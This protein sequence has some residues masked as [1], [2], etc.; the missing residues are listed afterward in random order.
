MRRKSL[1]CLAL[2]STSLCLG[3][4]AQDSSKPERQ[5]LAAVAGQPIYEEDLLPLIGNQ[6]Q[7]LQS[8]EFEL[9]SRALDILISQRVLQMEADKKGTTLEKLVAE[10]V[11]SK[12][13]EPTEGEVEAFYLA[14]RDHLSRPYE[15]VKDQLRDGLKQTKLQQA[16]Q[17]YAKSMR[18]SADVAIVFSP[19]R[20]EVGFDPARVR[21]DASAPVTI[22]EFADFQCPYCLKSYP[23]MKELLAKYKGRVKMAFRDFPLRGGH[24]QAQ[25]A[26]EAARCAGEQGKF[27]EYHDALF[28]NPEKLDEQA[29]KE[30]ARNLELNQES[31]ESCLSSGR[32]RPAIEEDVRAGTA[33]RVVG[34]PTFYVNGIQ[35][36]GAQPLT[37][38]EK[39]IEDE[40]SRTVKQR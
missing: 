35:M 12:V 4:R 14:Q 38:F 31:F 29:L 13:P 18:L 17:N 8:Q 19:A 7:Q 40:L 37:A 22:V 34:T 9:K 27:W 33:A 16:R 2:I 28:S 32:F 11:D 10:Q 30:R 21:G 20:T 15:E 36:A 39:T 3:G 26:A 5:P 25:L 24:P 1:I 23:V 6:L